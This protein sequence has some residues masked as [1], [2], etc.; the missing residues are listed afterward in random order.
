MTIDY[1]IQIG[2]P[3]TAQTEAATL[4]T[5]QSVF[6]RVNQ[7]FNNWN[8]QSEISCFNAAPA[9][10][11][12]LLS[13][14]LA[15]FLD[16]VDRLVAFSEGRFD[17]TVDPLQ[18]IWKLKLKEGRTPS[19]DELATLLP[20][21]GWH[22]VHLEGRLLWKD[23]PLTAIDLSSI[24]KG[25]AVDLL[26]KE[27]ADSGCKNIY[28]EWGGEIRTKG[29]HPSGRPWA[30][31]IVG[32]N[33][34]ISMNEQAIATSGNYL[35]KW[36]VGGISY[37]HLIDPHAKKPLS[38]TAEGITSASVSTTTCAEA[39]ALA[40]ALMLFPSREEALEWAQEKGL[41]AWIW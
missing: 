37:T 39:D 11:P 41:Q 23:H 13:Q 14:E 30:I 35:Q 32:I 36:Q 12:I 2:D 34:K 16:V 10:S 26:V 5:I 31:A 29:R 20:A 1:H 38:L 3:L 27:L 22:H 17:P 25:H 24:A 40:T 6:S 15:D 8:P 19:E 33:K 4:S 9:Y 7:T 18:K 21:I 28:V